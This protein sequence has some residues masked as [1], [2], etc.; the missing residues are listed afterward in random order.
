MKPARQQ[1][2]RVQVF[3]DRQSSGTSALS[4]LLPGTL[5]HAV[6]DREIQGANAR[7]GRDQPE[8][9][10]TDRV[11][12]ESTD[13]GRITERLQIIRVKRGKEQ[14]GDNNGHQK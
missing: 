6:G 14:P 4:V 9:Q 10:E 8:T 12:T 13:L 7:D 1:C 2:P 3:W 11:D 5:A